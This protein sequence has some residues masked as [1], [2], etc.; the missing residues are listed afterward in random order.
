[1]WKYLVIA[2]LV[3]FAVAAFVFYKTHT[4]MT[5]SVGE[6]ASIQEQYEAAINKNKDVFMDETIDAYAKMRHEWLV[7]RKSDLE[8]EKA[9]VEAEDSE[10]VQETTELNAK[11]EA[12][13]SEIERERDSIKDAMKEIA[14][15]VDFSGSVE[16]TG[17]DV[18]P[19]DDRDPDIF[20]KIG[21]N[22]AALN[23]KKDQQNSKLQVE[24]AEVEARVAKRDELQSNIAVEDAIARDRR[25]R[26]SPAEL[27]CHVAVTDPEWD[28]VILDRGADAGIVIGSRLA[29]MRG[30]KKICELNVTLVEA[31]R[32][33]GDVVFNTLVVGEAV[34]AGDRVIAVRTTNK[35]N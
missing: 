9:R 24:V 16:R 13:F 23:A 18:D 20:E 8:A 15:E 25:A 10:L 34:K 21:A 33:S 7:K 2:S 35:E 14:G 32:A 26:I 5:T 19:L 22:M 6:V 30:E 12:L 29:V 27:E 3:F 17:A 31:N 28:L 11:W 4:V 1:M